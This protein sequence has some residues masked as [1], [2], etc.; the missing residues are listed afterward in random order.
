M[1]AIVDTRAPINV[2]STKFVKKIDILLDINYQKK[3]RAIGSY[4]T[5]T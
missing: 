4:F 2:V 5:Q 1:Y 3:F